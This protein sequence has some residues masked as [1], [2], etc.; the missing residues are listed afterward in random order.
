MATIC[1]K[2][3][4]NPLEFG[5]VITA[6]DGRIERFLE[7]PTWGQ[8]FSD[9]INTGIYVLEPEV[10]D[11]VAPGQAADFSSEVFPA[12]LAAHAPLYGFVTERYWEDVGTL[13][14][15]LSAH[16]DV[17]DQKVTVEIDAF[18]LRP[19]VFVGAGAEIDPSAIVESPV[20]IGDNCRIGPGARL[21]PYTV[22]GSNVRVG[23][24]AELE[25]SVVHDNCFLGPAV[26]AHGTGSGDR[27]LERAPR[28]ASTSRRGWCSA[29]TAASAA[30]R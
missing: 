10:L 28:R 19:G 5:I 9:T 26:N 24:S 12:L 25:Q 23:D 6:A 1:L 18:P 11:H 15:Y 21:G 30:R 17:L 13:E 20:L 8:V 22:L 4:E 29:T 27:P 7:K 16:K 2:P 3:I 14:G